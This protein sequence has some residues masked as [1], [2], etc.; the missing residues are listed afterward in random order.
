[1]LKRAADTFADKTQIIE[2]AGA[3]YV[4]TDELLRRHSGF[5]S[6]LLKEF[7]LFGRP[8]RWLHLDG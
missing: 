4:S 8:I 1:M 2:A 5:F 3:F 6:F 7:I